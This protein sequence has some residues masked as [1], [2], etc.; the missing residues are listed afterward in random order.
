[1]IEVVKSRA[2]QIVC[3]WGLH[4]PW[5]S[6]TQQN[7]HQTNLPC[8]YGPKKWHQQKETKCLR[9][10]HCFSRDS[11]RSKDLYIY[12][13]F[14]S[15]THVIPLSQKQTSQKKV[16]ISGKSWCI[17]DLHGCFVEYNVTKH[18]NMY[19][20]CQRIQKEKEKSCFSVNSGL[21][22]IKESAQVLGQLSQI[23]RRNHDRWNLWGSLGM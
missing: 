20:V 23:Y 8:K 19:A 9:Q 16:Y 5:K 22:N 6:T 2:F 18:T 21:K 10:V 13:F 11:S 12:A 1:M 17:G 15:K 3:T 14:S 4:W 7:N